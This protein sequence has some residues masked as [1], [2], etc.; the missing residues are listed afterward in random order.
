MISKKTIGLFLLL[1]CSIW[2]TAKT[3]LV[4]PQHEITSLKNAISMAV[5]GD[6][7]IVKKGH[8]KEG[9]ITVTK[10][11]VFIGEDYPLLDGEKG[12]GLKIQE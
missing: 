5:D 3:I 12:S 8:Y 9:N 10:S 2:T 11:L 7:I 6:T 1:T 4:G